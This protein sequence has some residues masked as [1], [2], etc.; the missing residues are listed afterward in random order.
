VDEKKCVLSYSGPPVECSFGAF[1]EEYDDFIECGQEC[2]KE[3]WYCVPADKQCMQLAMPP[4]PD[5]PPYSSQAACEEECQAYYCCWVS[6]GD[7][8]KGS[9]CQLGK[10]DDGFE[11]SGPHDDEGICEADCNSIYCWSYYDTAISQMVKVCQE[12]SPDECTPLYS[13]D[14]QLYTNTME[15]GLQK[16]SELEDLGFEVDDPVQGIGEFPELFTVKYRCP[17]ELCDGLSCTGDPIPPDCTH[18]DIQ[19]VSGPY[20]RETDCNRVCFPPEYRWFCKDEVCTECCASG[21]CKPT[22]ITCPDGGTY[23]TEEDCKLS[24]GSPCYFCEDGTL[25][26]D[27]LPPDVCLEFGGSLTKPE[28]CSPPPQCQP[29]PDCQDAF[30]SKAQCD[31]KQEAWVNCSNNDCTANDFQEAKCLDGL[32]EALESQGWNVVV[33]N[34]QCCE[35][36][37]T[38]SADG[39]QLMNVFACCDGTADGLV[40]NFIYI[41]RNEDD[42]CQW[43]SGLSGVEATF[44]DGKP[45]WSIQRCNPPPPP[46]NCPPGKFC[47]WTPPDPCSTGKCFSFE[48]DDPIECPEG[49][50]YDCTSEEACNQWYAAHPNP[51]CDCWFCED[52]TWVNK[53]SLNC[54]N[55]GGILGQKPPAEDCL[56]PPEYTTPGWYVHCVAAELTDG[57]GNGTGVVQNS[58]QRY[59]FYS[60][61]PRFPMDLGDGDYAM[62]ILAGPFGTIQGAD[63]WIVANGGV[64]KDCVD[65]GSPIRP[66]AARLP[67]NPLP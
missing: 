4:T 10:C 29:A 31:G 23:N 3:Q 18:E 5:A 43:C 60:S 47:S 53:P 32:P 11:K 51:P 67:E 25:T 15:E 35:C 8:T 59:Y 56:P 45:V 61:M 9:Y 54:I 7:P 64:D 66:P 38:G 52:G 28:D 46:P 62:K 20:G 40:A 13:C 36:G 48:S 2:L 49:F 6:Q 17:L 24:C 22:D 30:N 55:E 14:S 41:P 33:R 42:P 19:K 37:P 34:E 1:C 65:A 57:N 27:H 39:T 50:P 58:G 16:K 12:D 63:A 44:K 21:T 26:E